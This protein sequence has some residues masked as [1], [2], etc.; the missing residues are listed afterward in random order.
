MHECVSFCIFCEKFAHLDGNMVMSA[1]NDLRTR[2][3]TSS[4]VSLRFPV[5]LLQ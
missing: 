3:E 1:C 2:P 4:V 5:H